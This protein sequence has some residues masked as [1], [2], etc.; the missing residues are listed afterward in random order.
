MTA[1]A[2]STGYRAFAS[3]AYAKTR[4]SAR[5]SHAMTKTS[6]RRIA[7]TRRMEVA[8]ILRLLRTQRAAFKGSPEFV[9]PAYAKMRCSAR[10]SYAT[11]QTNAPKTLA[12][13]PPVDATTRPS[14]T[15]RPATFAGFQAYACPAYAKTRCSARASSATTQTNAPKTPATLP[16][17]AAFT[18]PSPTTAFV[19]STGF[20]AYACPAC[21]KTRCSA[22]ASSATTQSS[23]PKMSA[24]LPT[25]P[26][27]TLRSRTTPLATSTGFP[28]Y[29]RPGCDAL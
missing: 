8:A 12:A 14:R 3:P 19:A 5:A 20:Q 18:T 21:A 26:V 28:A 13:A 11:T 2:T 6:A 24:T 4:C 23:A 9:C 10:A 16:T 7:A 1:P 25:V 17:E 29:V 22:R 27:S 15:P